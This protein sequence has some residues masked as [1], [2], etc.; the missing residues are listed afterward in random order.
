MEEGTEEL[1]A[2]LHEKD[3]LISC[4]LDLSHDGIVVTDSDGKIL[5]A[6]KAMERIVGLIPNK[7]VG[8][9]IEDLVRVGI[10]PDDAVPYR[11][12]S[13]KKQESTLLKSRNQKSFVLS[14][15]TP[16]FDAN[17][18]LKYVITN[19][20]NIAEL[21]AMRTEVEAK[22][23]YASK[24]PELAEI[25]RS[26]VVSDLKQHG[27]KDLIVK[28]KKTVE[29]I[30]LIIS[31]VG[32]KLNY[33]ITGE[34]G[35]GKSLFAKI[36]HH[37]SDRKNESFVDLNCSAI[38]INLLES[39][40]FGYNE[41]SFTGASKRGQVGLL[42]IADKGTIFLDEIGTMPLELQSKILKFLDDKT[43]KRLGSSKPIELDVQVIAATN[44][45]LNEAIEAGTF[46]K[47]LFFR[48][49]ELTIEIPPLRERPADAAEMVDYFWDKYT[50][51]FHKEL[52][53]S[54]GARTKLINYPF[55]GNVREI[56]NILKRLVLLTKGP[57]VDIKDLGKVTNDHQA[58]HFAADA[59]DASEFKTVMGSFEKDIIKKAYET[60]GS[61]YAAAEALGMNQSTFFRR[62]KKYGII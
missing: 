29:I 24:L 20:R 7:I 51:E 46:R 56:R 16:Y 33:L 21:E 58:D 52:T 9:T 2:R 41:G 59:A 57:S 28:D 3:E 19:V 15:S 25:Y 62:A 39:E 40:L 30:E 54:E 61:T 32:F 8:K 34:T 35:T 1:L 26:K 13:S 4:I 49:N 10:I 47:D 27:I 38:P 12:L 43:F 14:T 17:G 55:P 18:K 31:L 36:I 53:L 50:Q 23:T 5:Y 60:H 11:A 22:D 48:L 45:N 42:E 44:A 37:L 6:G